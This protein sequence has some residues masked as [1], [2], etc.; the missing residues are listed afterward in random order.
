[1]RIIDAIVLGLYPAI[2]VFASWA[3]YLYVFRVLLPAIQLRRL[4][5]GDHAIMGGISALLVA[6]FIEDALYGP[7]RWG[8]GFFDKLADV[9]PLVGISKT[10]ILMGSVLAVFG[11]RH[12]ISGDDDFGRLVAVAGAV[13]AIG[14][15]S[16]MLLV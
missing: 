9:L 6:I 11:F 13:W 4:N 12:A 14:T 16:A 5:L 3:S 10:F 7:Q 15:V 8:V 2:A 1:M